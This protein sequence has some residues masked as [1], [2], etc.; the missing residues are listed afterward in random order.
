MNLICSE[1]I[2]L[3][4]CE[5]KREVMEKDN[6]AVVL[7]MNIKIADAVKP[8]VD[9]DVND[10]VKLD[11]IKDMN[12]V[13][14]MYNKRHVGDLYGVESNISEL[15]TSDASVPYDDYSSMYRLYDLN[16]VVS[17][18]CIR[19]N[20]LRYRRKMVNELED[21]EDCETEVLKYLPI[22]ARVTFV[23]F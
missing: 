7:D 3:C 22:P 17:D 21:L 18:L 1:N 20:F 4:D 8:K 5:D 10:A 14:D 12:N 23:S 11:E 13:S 16:V 9:A 2:S 15:G 6:E 19:I